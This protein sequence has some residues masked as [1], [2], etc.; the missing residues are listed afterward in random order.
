M[1]SYVNFA[2][3]TIIDGSYINGGLINGSSIDG[4]NGGCIDADGCH[5]VRRGDG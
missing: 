2:R 4:I 3:R 1:I 5:Y